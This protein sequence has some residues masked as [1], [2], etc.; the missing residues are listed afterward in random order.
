[1]TSVYVPFRTSTKA[2]DYGYDTTTPTKGETLAQDKFIREF[3][4]R[5]MYTGST[6]RLSTFFHRDVK[7]TQ[8]MLSHDRMRT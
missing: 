7:L 1:M 4:R 5:L 8:A 2:S 6:V 3:G